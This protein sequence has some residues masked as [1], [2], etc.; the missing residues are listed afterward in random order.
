MNNGRERKIYRYI[1][2]SLGM[3]I[4][5]YLAFMGA[6]YATSTP[7]FCAACHEVTPYVQSW[8][9]SPHKKLTCLFCHEKR[10]FL[11]KL[12]SKARGLNYVYQ[13]VTGQYSLL[14]ATAEI[15]QQNCIDCHFQGYRGFTDTVKLNKKHYYFIK[16]GRS[17]LECH[18][19]TGHKSAIVSIQQFAGK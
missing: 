13:H 19:D 18:R 15:P 10:G 16:E 6:Y 9:Q 11:G 8:K 14:F 17:C 4:G 3:I 2:I 1:L 5:L 7:G 12:D